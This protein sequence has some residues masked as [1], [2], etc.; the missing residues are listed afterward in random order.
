MNMGYPEQWFQSQRRRW[1]GLAYRVLGSVQDAEDVVQEAWLRWQRAEAVT[2]PDAWVRQTVVNLALDQLRRRRRE[3]GRYVGPWLPE[4][5]PERPD[6]LTPEPDDFAEQQQSLSLGFLHMLERLTPVERA[7]FVLREAFDTGFEEMALLL[8][9]SAVNCRQLYS[10]AKRKVAEA[11]ARHEAPGDTHARLLGTFLL[12]CQQGDV[13]LMEQALSREAI[14]Y[15]D[16]NG[17]VKGALRPI[18]GPA[19]IIRLMLALNRKQ[20]PGLAMSRATV[21]G[22]LAV[23]MREQDQVRYVVSAC[24]SAQGIVE[25]YFQQ[26]PDKLAGWCQAVG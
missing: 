12:A 4:P 20:P 9:K 13:G 2:N 16:T 19:K 3:A 18:Y 23:V 1:F 17:K 15:T 11:P 8:G 14:L 5:E 21:N 10:R 24:V 26:N 22:R 25:L 6:E 7:V